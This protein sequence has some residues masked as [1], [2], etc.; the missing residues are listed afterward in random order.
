MALYFLAFLKSPLITNHIK[1]W[2]IIVYYRT[3]YNNNINTCSYIQTYIYPLFPTGHCN[4]GVADLE[5]FQ[6][7][8]CAWYSFV[9]AMD[10]SGLGKLVGFH[11]LSF[12]EEF[13]TKSRPNLNE[14]KRE[15]LNRTPTC[16]QT[17][18]SF[19]GHLLLLHCVY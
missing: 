13:V 4:T 11:G 16:T 5:R 9:K 8:L 6:K 10:G 17:C 15:G 12:L 2:I 18:T 3:V 7:P 19:K 14:K 1:L